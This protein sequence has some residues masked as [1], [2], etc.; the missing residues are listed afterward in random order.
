MTKGNY[1]M[2]TQHLYEKID[3]PPLT[4]EQKRELENLKNMKDEDIDFSDIPKMTK[5][6]FEKGHLYYKQ[7]IT[8]VDLTKVDEEN[9][10]WILSVNANL[11]E[12][13]NEVLTWARIQHCPTMAI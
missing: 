13:L 11:S 2:R 9:K 8:M 6:D 3:F 10:N 4:E 5:E 1:I 7:P 12:K